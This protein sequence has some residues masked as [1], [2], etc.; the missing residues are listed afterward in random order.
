M[1]KKFIRKTRLIVTVK[2]DN[3]RLKRVKISPLRL[4]YIRTAAIV[5]VSLMSCGKFIQVPIKGLSNKEIKLKIDGII[6]H[7]PIWPPKVKTEVE[8]KNI[9]IVKNTHPDYE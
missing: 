2:D 8:N 1:K 9:I 6:H 5:N 7:S 4:K 3:G